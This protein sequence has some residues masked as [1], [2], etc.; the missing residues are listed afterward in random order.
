MR[1]SCGLQPVRDQRIDTGGG[2][3]VQS[4]GGGGGG[5]GNDDGGNKDLL[6]EMARLCSEWIYRSIC[7]VVAVA[8]ITN[9][10]IIENICVHILQFSQ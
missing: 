7:I 5:D 10:Q 8:F 9:I 4:D 6:N 2:G 3:V 1:K